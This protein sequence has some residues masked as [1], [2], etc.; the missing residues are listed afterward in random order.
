VFDIEFGGGGINTIQVVD[1]AIRL[2]EK[3]LLEGKPYDRVWAVFDKDSFTDAKFNAAILKANGNDIECAWSNEAFELWYLLHFHNRVTPMPRTDY[4]DA[5]SRAVNGSPLYVNKR[6]YVYRK[7]DSE[8]YSIM[9]KY[10]SQEH[11]IR[12]ARAI[13]KNYLD[14]SFSKHNPC[15]KVHRIVLQLMGEDE[16]LNEEIKEKANER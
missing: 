14:Q 9:N 6:R 5:I 12:Y 2:K 16:V 13:E 7:N 3:A 4:K 8:N 15:T 11:A 1:E 10:G